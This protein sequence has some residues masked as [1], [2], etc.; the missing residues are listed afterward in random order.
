MADLAKLGLNAN[1]QLRQGALQY[2]ATTAMNQFAR[3]LSQQRGQRNLQDFGKQQNKSLT[4]LNQS[5]SNRGLRNSGVRK[6]GVS[7]FASDATR[8]RQ[9]IMNQT[10]DEQTG[11]DLQQRANDAEYQTLLA[12]IAEDKSQGI[13]DLFANLSQFYPFLGS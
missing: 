4:K 7:D 10:R 8:A 12:N 5:Y 6:Q 11:I 3:G 1:K 9:D 2:G 13:F